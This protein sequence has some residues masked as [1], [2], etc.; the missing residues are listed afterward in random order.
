MLRP[1]RRCTTP[2]ATHVS[3]REGRCTACRN[4]QRRT[5]N[6]RRESYTA[7]YGPEWPARRLD[8]LTRNPVCQLCPRLAEVADHHPRGI[9]LL[10]KHAVPDPHLDRYLRPLCKQCH[11]RETAR[12]EPGGWNRD[13]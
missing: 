2:G 10:R 5:L 11:D 3:D 6:H 1:P 13:R 4:R 8:Y 9:R 7:M 12:R